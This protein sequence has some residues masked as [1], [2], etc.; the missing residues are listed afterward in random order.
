MQKSTYKKAYKQKKGEKRATPQNAHKTPC[1]D[2]QLVAKKPANTTF[3]PANTA[4][5]VNTVIPQKK[6]V[7]L[8]VHP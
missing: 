8:F 7:R 5:T 1:I 3:F 4:N 2:N 6:G